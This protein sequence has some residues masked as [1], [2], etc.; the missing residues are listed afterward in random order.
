MH[1]FNSTLLLLFVRKFI[2]SLGKYHLLFVGPFRKEQVGYTMDYLITYSSYCT[3][4]R[5]QY[6]LAIQ[7]SGHPSN[8]VS[9]GRLGLASYATSLERQN[10]LCSS[11]AE[12]SGVQ[13]E[14]YIASCQRILY[15]T[16]GYKEMSSTFPDQ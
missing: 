5:A 1:C 9:K 8:A 6:R 7:S 13:F 4:C 12:I 14:L 11:V 3:V 2:H 10:V 15:C 16:G